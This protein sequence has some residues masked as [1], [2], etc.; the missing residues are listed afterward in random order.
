[1]W[2]TDIAEALMR[3]LSQDGVVLS[4]AFF[5][6]LLSSYIEDSRIAIEKF[7]ALALLK[8]CPATGTPRSTPPKPSWTA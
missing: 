7:H 6:T 1:V 4:E 5:K 2:E 8:V 3:V